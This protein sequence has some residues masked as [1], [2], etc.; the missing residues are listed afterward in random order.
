M[1]CT[2][3]AFAGRTAAFRHAMSECVYK[4]YGA[5]DSEIPGSLPHVLEVRLCV[6]ANAD[7]R[8]CLLEVMKKYKDNPMVQCLF[9][10]L[11]QQ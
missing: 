11:H 6:M 1:G 10:A 2:K 4:T 8:A 9:A 5:I 3:S 7:S